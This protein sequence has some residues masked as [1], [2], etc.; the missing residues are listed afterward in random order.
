[1]R[2]EA[3]DGED[4]K[5]SHEAGS[6]VQEAEGY[7]VPVGINEVRQRRGRKENGEEKKKKKSKKER[8]KGRKQERKKR[9]RDGEIQKEDGKARSVI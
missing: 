7:G 1:M 4:D 2:H 9:K 3:Q 5:P 8:S 6:T